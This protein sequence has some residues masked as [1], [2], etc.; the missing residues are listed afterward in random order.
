[1]THYDTQY[2]VIK[3]KGHIKLSTIMS[4]FKNSQILKEVDMIPINF[5]KYIYL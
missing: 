1:M 2:Q 4:V 3:I 5:Y